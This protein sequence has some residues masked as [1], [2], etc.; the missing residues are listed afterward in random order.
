V[1]SAEVRIWQLPSPKQHAPVFAGGV[2]SIVSAG[3]RLSLAF[4]S[5]SKRLAVL[6]VNSLPMTIQP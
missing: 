6:F 5:E 2:K 1:Q 3:R 4:W